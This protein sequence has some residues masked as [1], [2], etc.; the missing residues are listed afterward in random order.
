MLLKCCYHI[1]AVNLQQQKNVYC[2]G[3]LYNTEQTK[4]NQNIP[5]A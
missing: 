3:N 5:L 1:L 4:T 2:V